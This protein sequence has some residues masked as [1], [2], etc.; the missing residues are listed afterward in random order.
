MALFEG[1]TPAERNKT[2]AALALGA[3]ALIVLGR[4]FFGSSG[5]GTQTGTRP[6]PTPRRTV[7]QNATN[8]TDDID[9][10][11]VMTPI[12]WGGTRVGGAEA[13]RNIFAYYARPVGP[14]NPAG[15]A[16]PT[17][18]PPTPTPTPPLNM[19]SLSPSSVYARTSAFTLQISGDKFTPAT[20]VYLDG[21]E[22]PTE[23][24]SPQQLTANVPAALIAAP[25]ARQVM[26]RTPDNQLYSNTATLNVMQ[27]PVPTYTYVGF[28]ARKRNEAAV[29]KNQK[30]D[31]VSVQVNDT[32]EG[33]FRVAAISERSVDL[34]DKE[35][36]IKHT[37]PY[38]DPRASIN[39][40]R[41][42]GSVL[43]PPPPPRTEDEGEEEP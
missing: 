18:P 43:P 16:T 35:L 36:S 15:G 4:M 12:V 19:A 27:P 39:G 22:A 31:L 25:G 24:K 38:V 20:R 1:K 14:V 21:Q 37:L 13:G 32:I 41:P 3:I 30:G 7:Q 23:Y 2:I 17:P 10:N 40:L 11:V 28:I 8:T 9:P 6:T 5:P 26:V 29:L 34:V 42:L 33:R